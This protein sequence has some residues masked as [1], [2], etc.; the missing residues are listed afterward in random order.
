MYKLFMNSIK[1]KRSDPHS[2]LLNISAK[3]DLIKS[4]KYPALSKLSIYYTWKKYKKV[5]QKQ[6]I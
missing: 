6:L 3:I 2:I 1:T 5:I 4:D